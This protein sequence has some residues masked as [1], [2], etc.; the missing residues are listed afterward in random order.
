MLSKY[1][2]ANTSLTLLCQT[3]TIKTKKGYI[4]NKT[5]LTLSVTT[6]ILLS[7]CGSSDDGSGIST[8]AT[9]DITV[10]RGPVL[11]ATTRDA[12][13]QIGVSKGNGVYSFTDPV[14]P[15]ESFG[16]Y[17]DINRNGIVDAGD[18][19]MNNFHL[20]TD[21]GN[22]MTIA[23][24]MAENNETLQ[25]M[26][27]SG[28]T[29]DELYSQRPSTDIDNAALSDE[30]YKYCVEN[31][32]TDASNL[33]AADI[34][35]LK[36]KIELRQETYRASGFDAQELEHSLVNDELHI[37]IMHEEDIPTVELSA[38]ENIIYSI[39]ASDLNTTQKA[40]LA[41]MWDEE[42]LARDL[43]LSLN[44]LTPSTTLYNIATNAESKHVE[45]VEM[46]VEKYDLNL[47]NADN[48]YT[49][50]Y[51]ETDLDALNDREFIVP[52]LTTLYATLY[53]EGS[54]SQQAALEV[55]CKV[56]VTDI[57]DLDRD[58]L[59]AGDAQD[60]SLVFENLRAG[61]YAHYWAFDKALKNMGV[62][63]GCCSL[64]DEF[65]KTEGEYPMDK[66]AEGEGFKYRHSQH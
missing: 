2:S 13:G 6:A 55:G 28:F 9:T 34:L 37:D 42:R 57:N 31:N 41:Y 23:T 61:S 14:Y 16:G 53:A 15:I 46:L 38:D 63:T 12:K 10:E 3:T 21:A 33:S 49:G 29:H 62:S 51:S 48:N 18:V 30:V 54:L 60:I 50:G 52:E 11:S 40:T 25:L 24:T 27:E 43:Y 22:V 20:K 64:G 44:A 65:C 19:A 39:A 59:L 1:S 32:I 35:E 47:L 66:K 45:S 17:I 36:A 56:E 8:A 5:L 58:I 4:M 7:G 26:L